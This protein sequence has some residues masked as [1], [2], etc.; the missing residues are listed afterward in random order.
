[1]AEELPVQ[2]GWLVKEPPTMFGKKH[3]RW[4]VLS[5]SKCSYFVDASRTYEKGFFLVSEIKH[6]EPISQH[7]TKFQ[8]VTDTRTWKLEADTNEIMCNW[9]RSFN[10]QAAPA[11]DMISVSDI[12]IEGRKPEEFRGLSVWLEIPGLQPLVESVNARISSRPHRAH[13]AL[14]YGITEDKYSLEKF[15][16][17]ADK[18]TLCYEDEWSELSVKRTSMEVNV[19]QSMQIGFIDL[20][21]Q[22]SKELSELYQMASDMFYSNQT[23]RS[24]VRP[25]CCVAYGDLSLPSFQNEKLEDEL[26]KIEMEALYKFG[27]VSLWKT[28][29]P[30]ES[31]EELASYPIEVSL[32]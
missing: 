12:D 32:S 23:L 13:I 3:R 29:G 20:Y 2:T 26:N 16:K 21:F 17:L 22:L 5:Q 1:M 15:R 27:K 9:V 6:A 24:I 28:D 25:R 8:V 14:L 19:S 30:A 7:G 10:E 11:T 18:I 4:F 31:W